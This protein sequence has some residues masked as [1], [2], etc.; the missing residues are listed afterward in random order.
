MRDEDL[1]T[2]C[3]AELDHRSWDVDAYLAA[4][5][6]LP[7]SVQSMLRVASQV[8]AFPTPAPSPEFRDRVSARLAEK[9]A[10]TPRRRPARS[11]FLVLPAK[12][13]FRP[14]TA[15]I[16]ASLLI[17][18][19]MGGVLTASAAAIPGSALYPTKLAAEKVQLLLAASPSSQAQV[20]LQI[21][22]S[23]LQEAQS[24]IQTGNLNVVPQLLQSSDQALTAAQ[25]E[26][27]RTTS[28]T[29]RSQ[30]ELQITTVRGEDQKIVP[31]LT[32]TVPEQANREIGDRTPVAAPSATARSTVV[33]AVAS[34]MDTPT[35]EISTDVGKPSVPEVIR[36]GV[37][38]STL[39]SPTQSQV[40]LHSLIQQATANNPIEALATARLYATAVQAERTRPGSSEQLSG[41]RSQIDD[42]LKSVPPSARSAILI[43]QE[44]LDA[45]LGSSTT[46]TSSYASTLAT[47]TAGPEIDGPAPTA[48]G[49]RMP[50]AAKIPHA[51]SP[52]AEDGNANQSRQSGDGSAPPPAHTSVPRPAVVVSTNTPTSGQHSTT[53]T[54]D[55]SGDNNRGQIDNSSKASN[56]Q[57]ESDQSSSHTSSNSGTAASA[58]QSDQSIATT[59]NDHPTRRDSSGRH[60]DPQATGAGKS[61]TMS[62]S[63]R[64]GQIPSGKGDQRAGQPNNGTKGH[65]KSHDNSTSSPSR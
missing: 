34:K 58:R 60:I 32:P 53:T 56:G 16:A 6:D 2:S 25:T 11:W 31:L 49:D 22:Q 20:H 24:E 47:A 14:V 26:V 50:V 55:H 21:A 27:A 30:I 62:T 44:A 51:S 17:I 15:P 13:W 7:V 9:I 57:G 38:P 1:L 36:P 43:A 3:L 4:R 12:A 10:A 40:L 18:G 46:N 48:V 65:N 45:T 39:G 59:R 42:A 64:R 19:G 52:S 63:A 23:R 8:K 35:R 29:E 37:T 61:A 41:E 5:P 54:S 28:P 33:I